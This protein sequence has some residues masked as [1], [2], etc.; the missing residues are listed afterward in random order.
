MGYTW[1]GTLT[2]GFAVVV[3][4][5]VVAVTGGIKYIGWLNTLAGGT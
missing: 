4:L 2:V 1:G 5:V 3:I